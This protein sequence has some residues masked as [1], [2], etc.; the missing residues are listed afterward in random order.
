[1]NRKKMEV[2]VSSHWFWKNKSNSDL[3]EQIFLSTDFVF[4]WWF[5]TKRLSQCILDGSP[6]YGAFSH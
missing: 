6:K 3:D 4:S 1:M 2:S 5:E